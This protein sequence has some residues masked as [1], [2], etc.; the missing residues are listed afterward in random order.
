MELLEEFKTCMSEIHEEVSQNIDLI[1]HGGCAIFAVELV[2]RMRKLGMNPN[3]R[4]YGEE[5]VDVSLAE[6]NILEEYGNPMDVEAWNDNGVEFV[7][8]V[9]EWGCY[10]WDAECIESIEDAY[11]YGWNDYPLL[12]G[13]IS[14][15]ALRDIAFQ[16]VGWNSTYD[17]SQNPMLY[18]I[19]DNAFKR[20]EN[21]LKK[22]PMAA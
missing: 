20:L 12:P 1:N 9:V 19:L 15:N 10:L 22:D 16:R 21:N 13:E 14:Y 5:E 8:I 17:R 2:K 3:I 7:H 11:E 6:T 18:R 4:V